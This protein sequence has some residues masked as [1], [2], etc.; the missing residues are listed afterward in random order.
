MNGREQWASKL[1][2]ILAAVGSAVGLGNIWRFSY[3]A[4][5]SGGAAFLL[6][7]V[8]CIFLIGL[9]VLLAEFTIGRKGQTDV[10]AAFTSKAPGKP[11][12]LGGFFG[13][14][15]S[16][17][18]LSFYGVIAGWVLYYIYS[19]FTGTA[20][21]VEE[22]GYGDFFESFIGS[23]GGPIF[24]QVLFMAIVIGI[25]Y[26]GVKKGIELSNK[27]F[28]PLLAVILLFLAG[29]SLTLD[30]A[31]EGLQFLFSPEWSAFG[32][33]E[34]WSAAVGQA[35]FTL[36]LGMGAMIT[37]SSYLSKDNRLPSAAGTVVVLD[38]L[39]A[40]VAGLVIFPAVFSFG[41]DPGDG[42]GLI[43]VTL[44]EVFNLMGGGGTVFAIFFFILVALAALSSA[45][46]LLEVSVAFVMRKFNWARKQ[47]ALVVGLLITAVGIPSALSQGGPL[48]EATIAGLPFLDFVDTLTDMYFLPLGGLMIALFVGWGWRR[49]DAF[50]ES[51]LTGSSIAPLWIWFLR[52]VAPLGILWILYL[53]VVNTPFFQ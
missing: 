38:T 20:G 51:D 15:A 47:A 5:E 45:I 4:G 27:I 24:W 30:G 2:F 39:F 33:A 34:V 9:P 18:I 43:F 13:L 48:T 36:S 44:P 26:F 52:I 14:A 12:V 17:F 46:S 7:Y 50:R 3:V 41:I 8:I 32:D 21:A 40:I 1:G 22:G 23:S 16:F 25:V 42:P 28:M 19:Y 49:E 29:F 35:F 53:N 31:S 37:Y 10:I 6:I 11:W